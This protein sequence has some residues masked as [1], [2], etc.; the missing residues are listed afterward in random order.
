M[1]SNMS[2]TWCWTSHDHNWANGFWNSLW[3][4][5]SLDYK[6][7]S[8][9]N[10]ACKPRFYCISQTHHQE[11]L[12]SC[13]TFTSVSGDHTFLNLP[14][15]KLNDHKLSE[16]F[17]IRKSLI[18]HIHI[19]DIF[20]RYRILGQNKAFSMVSWMESLILFTL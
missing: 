20:S 12:R 1:S 4:T 17:T 15:Q 3:Y 13:P 16:F 19:S 11:L 14:Y 2:S 5:S 9:T 18:L 8:K 10:Y 7:V 6:H